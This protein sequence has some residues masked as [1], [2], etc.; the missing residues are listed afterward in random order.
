MRWARN[1]VDLSGPEVEI[2]SLTVVAVDGDGANI[3]PIH[4]LTRSEMKTAFVERMAPHQCPNLLEPISVGRE[5][6][7]GAG[8]ERVKKLRRERFDRL[9]EVHDLEAE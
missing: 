6:N 7:V 4:G 2:A 5:H 1:N 9:V 8:A 3:P